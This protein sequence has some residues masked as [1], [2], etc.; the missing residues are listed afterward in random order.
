VVDGHIVSLISAQNRPLSLFWLQCKFHTKRHRAQ[1]C[2]DKGCT[3]TLFVDDITVSGKHATMAL[4]HRIKRVL[5]SAGLVTHEDRS[6][7][8]G[9]AVIIT[10]AVREDE[11][12]RLR[13]KHRKSIVGSLNKLE[14]DGLTIEDQKSLAAKIA[15]AKCVD[16][17][18]TAPLKRKFL[19]LS[20]SNKLI[21]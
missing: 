5:S 3:V 11:K 13:N 4:L 8:T 1:I 17:I 7:S 12:L 16:E 14:A 19:E 10:G 6:A 20:A 9:S 15:A 21:V 18:G 2:L